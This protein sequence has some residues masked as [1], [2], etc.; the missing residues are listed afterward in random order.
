MDGYQ[1]TRPPGPPINQAY[2]SNQQQAR[3]PDQ[4]A[5]HSRA[6][7]TQR[8]NASPALPHRPP[9]PA[10]FSKNEIAQREQIDKDGEGLTFG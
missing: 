6:L 1:Q 7:E 10:K 3:R 2:I 5:V 4:A 9:K 8:G